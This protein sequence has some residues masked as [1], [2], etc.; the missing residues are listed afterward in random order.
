MQK[1]E[2]KNPLKIDSI[3]L[4]TDTNLMP[5]LLAQNI[6]KYQELH[7]NIAPDQIQITE[8]RH[9]LKIATKLLVRIFHNRPDDDA[10]ASEDSQ[11]DAPIESKGKIKESSK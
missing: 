6:R 3:I 9:P 5:D 8:L 1:S 10:D 4:E 11:P 7:G 2:V